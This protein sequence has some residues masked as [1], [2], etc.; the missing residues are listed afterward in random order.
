MAEHS[1]QSWSL[2]Q[3]KSKLNFEI[4]NAGFKVN[5]SFSGLE[6]HI[7]FEE[8]QAINA[9]VQ[10]SL[11]VAS[12]NTRNSLRDTH[13]KQ[14]D[15]FY[16]QKYPRITFQT[17]KILKDERGFRALGHLEIKGTSRAVEIPFQIKEWEKGLLWE[18]NFELNRLDYKVGSPSFILD[19]KVKVIIQAYLE[20][21]S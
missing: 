1:N 5:G 7:E 3:Q 16:V 6:A 12:I 4:R 19:K 14:A 2:N 15:Y 17:E 18:G 20:K 21:A 11:S 10:A 8:A 13:L 9:K